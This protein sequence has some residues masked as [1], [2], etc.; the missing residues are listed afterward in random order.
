MKKF[1]LMVA[2]MTMATINV[3]AQNESKNEVGVFYGMLS[4]SNVVSDI[5]S[6]ISAATGDKSSF[7]GPIGV[8]YYYH[9]TPAIGLG[10]VV[11]YAG[12]KVEDEKT[13][14]YDLTENFFTVMPSVKFNW[15]RKKHFGM[16]SALSVGAMFLTIGC[17]ENAKA[18][19]PNAKDETFTVLML[20]ATPLGI[21]F[22]G[23]QFRGFVETGVG[24][25]GI[26]SAG[27]RYKF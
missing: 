16:Y 3:N 15:L 25:K 6:A 21:E 23:E 14:K 24:E 9:V 11:T 17:N 20:Q 8:E 7:F 22:G 26:F 13:K 1:L 5:T 12:C 10:A 4:I 2:I 27:L 18:A 19:D